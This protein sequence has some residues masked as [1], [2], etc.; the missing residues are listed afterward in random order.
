[1]G[2]PRALRG[3][4]AAAAVLFLRL[5]HAP[6]CARLVQQPISREEIDRLE[7]ELAT[8]A[9]EVLCLLASLFST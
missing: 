9:V 7:E 4:A 2:L 5:F 1:M 3:G 6:T 8:L